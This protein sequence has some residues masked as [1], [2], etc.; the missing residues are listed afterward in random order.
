MALIYCQK[1]VSFGSHSEKTIHYI[2]Y[3]CIEL[4]PAWTA[5]WVTMQRSKQLE[6]GV[7]IFV[8]V[9]TI[10][11]PTREL[12]APQPVVLMYCMCTTVVCST[13]YKDTLY[14]STAGYRQNFCHRSTSRLTNFETFTRRPFNHIQAYAGFSKRSLANESSCLHLY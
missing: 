7:G 11:L 10:V 1:R 3:Y 2:N 13:V 9:R 12:E 8:V 14:R 5:L 4:F 6:T